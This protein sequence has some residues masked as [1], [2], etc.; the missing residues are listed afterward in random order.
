MGKTYKPLKNKNQYVVVWLGKLMQSGRLD[1]ARSLLMVPG[2]TKFSN[3]E[4]Y[5]RLAHSFLAMM[6][7]MRD[8]P[9][10]SMA[11]TS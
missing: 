6:S 7:C 2:H 3:D 4:L 9:T 1:E 11:T 5:A 10:A 8:L